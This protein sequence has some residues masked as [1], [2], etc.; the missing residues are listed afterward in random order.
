VMSRN[1]LAER[2]ALLHA[3]QLDSWDPENTY[4]GR[5]SNGM[6]DLLTW[7]DAQVL[8]A[9]DI[10]TRSVAMHSWGA[11]L[12]PQN[13]ELMPMQVD[14]RVSTRGFFDLFGL[15]FLHGGTWA[16]AADAEAQYV[17]VITRKLAEELFGVTDAVGRTVELNGRQYTVTGV[18]EDWLPAP[19]VH[20][21]S[22]GS[23]S[24][25]AQVYLPLGLHQALELFSWGNV[26][27][28]DDGQPRSETETYRDFL[29]STCV[30]L[31][32]WVELPDA[33]A[34]ERYERF[35]GNY[36]AEQKAQGRFPRP[37]QYALSRP[38]EWLVLNNVVGNDNR[39]L[40]WLSFAFLLVCVANTVA[41]LL[42]KFLRKA[43]EAGVR[44]ALGA[45][46]GAVV[47]QHLVESALVG[48]VGGLVGLLLAQLGLAGI[49]LQLSEQLAR[50]VQMDLAM[51]AVALLV[52][53]GASLLAGLY[54][55]W[56]I[57]QTS[58]A[59]YLKTQ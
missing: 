58:P 2:D 6:P 42:A 41:L 47:V 32:F 12:T 16:E 21:L 37:A 38:S 4:R 49:R 52:A 8:L 1:P 29:Q 3:G 33:A 50:V 54:P 5:V 19:T 25:P 15:R 45:S 51:V 44:R 28:W 14:I 7:R 30:W 17:T 56:R 27:C 46:R 24:D 53:L 48:A 26:N 22:T 23:F 39:L 13:P 55:A 34:R 9:S 35:L 31:Q 11:A 18:V 43:P 57:G 36:I 59:H 40:T 20:D 10:P